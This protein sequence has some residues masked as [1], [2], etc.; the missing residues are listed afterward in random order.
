MGGAQLGELQ[1]SGILTL[2]RVADP[3]SLNPFGIVQ[4]AHAPTELL[5]GL[6][7]SLRR[8]A[9]CVMRRK[10]MWL[11]AA[12]AVAVGLG[13]FMIDLK[14]QRPVALAFIG[15]TNIGERTEA[16]FWFSNRNEPDFHWRLLTRHEWSATGWVEVPRDPA[17]LDF[18]QSY[19]PASGLPDVDIV[20]V[21]IEQT[22]VPMRA[23]LEYWQQASV[24]RRRQ[25]WWAEFRANWGSTNPVKFSRQETRQVTGQTMMAE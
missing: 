22:N 9:G 18:G 5:H 7:R 13:L 23:T 16:R 3:R 21:P 6:A 4:F 12:L 15:F 14:P 17:G 10:F 24:R 11:A 25:I 8:P 19:G 1:R 20:G 2:L